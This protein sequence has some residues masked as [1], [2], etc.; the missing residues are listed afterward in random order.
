MYRDVYLW[1]TCV[2][3]V[4]SEIENEFKVPCYPQSTPRSWHMPDRFLWQLPRAL[5]LRGHLK[6]LRSSAS[7]A[8]P[9]IR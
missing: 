4:E 8:S 5:F 2:N 3:V 6:G 7:T 1:V 9:S